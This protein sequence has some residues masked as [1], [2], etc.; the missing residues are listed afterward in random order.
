M[1]QKISS[2]VMKTGRQTNGHC[3][4]MTCKF[5]CGMQTHTSANVCFVQA[6]IL[7][8]RESSVY[9][10]RNTCNQLYFKPGLKCISL[11]TL[12]GSSMVSHH[13]NKFKVLQGPRVYSK[14]SVVARMLGQSLAILSCGF[15]S[16][17]SWPSCLLMI[18]R[19][20]VCI[21]QKK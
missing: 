3:L 18:V 21:L 13:V 16:F 12:S 14:T 8:G 5:S 17:S 9:A 20:H 1:S 10:M 7:L 2:V 4:T 15:P 6:V 19:V 11:S